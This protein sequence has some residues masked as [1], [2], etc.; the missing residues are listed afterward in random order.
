MRACPPLWPLVPLYWWLVAAAAE[1]AVAIVLAVAVPKDK[2][3]WDKPV[4]PAGVAASRID[5]A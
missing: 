2:R 1:Q 3:C 5:R 4:C